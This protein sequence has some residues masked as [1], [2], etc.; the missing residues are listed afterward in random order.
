MA[1]LTAEQ[2][3]ELVRALRLRKKH[4]ESKVLQQFTPWEP[5]QA[6]AFRSN[7]RNRYV[8]GGNR[9]GKTRLGS[10]DIA[11]Q[12]LGT[13][14]YRKNKVPM[15]I[16]VI[17]TDFPN[18]I[19]NTI[20]PYLLALIPANQIVKTEKTQQ[21]IINKIIGRNGSVIDI[22]S[23]DQ[24]D[25][26]FESF[27]ADYAWFDEPPPENIYKGIRR[28]LIDRRGGMLVTMTPLGN[29]P[30]AIWFYNTLWVPALAGEVKDTECFILDTELNPY[31]SKD[32]LEDLKSVYTEEELDT[33]LHGKFALVSGLI[34]KHFRKEVHVVPYFSW[35][36][37]WPVWRCIDPHPKKPHC[38]TW[39][40]VTK[41][42]QKVVLD[43][44]KFDGPLLKLAERIK[45]IEAQNKYR[46]VDQL[47]DTSIKALDRTDQLKLLAD[48]GLRCRFPRKHDNVLPGIERVQQM[49]YPKKTREGTWWSELIMRD[50]CRHHVSEFMTYAW[51]GSG[52]PIKKGDDF[53][54]NVRYIISVN[55]QYCYAAKPIT[56]VDGFYV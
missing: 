24:E 43:E 38:V 33:R 12:F 26:K 47:I 22:L 19:R 48:A 6:D 30:N 23:Y 28:G 8:L 50:N 3:K 45:Q 51:D 36:E 5:T 7:R 46:V 32:E 21:G 13:H 44:L 40:G 29:D 4:A 27:S 2:K 9:S 10:V 16:K 34:Y 11:H 37:S 35:P 39:L 49:L 41:D 31:I 42:E 53:M 17:G 52:K 1:N 14:P 15:I 55:P 18:G 25:V 56:Y 20:L 54:D